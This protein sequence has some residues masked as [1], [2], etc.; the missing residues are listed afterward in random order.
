MWI[1]LLR[2]PVKHMKIPLETAAKNYDRDELRLEGSD[3][4]SEESDFA[5]ELDAECTGSESENV[6]ED[7]ENSDDELNDY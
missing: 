5:D 2:F 3:V 6:S 4:G 7:L 1:I